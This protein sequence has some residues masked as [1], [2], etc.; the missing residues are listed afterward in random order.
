M[1]ADP[2]DWRAPIKALT[3]GDA[4]ETMLAFAARQETAIPT[5]RRCGWTVM[6]GWFR[7]PGVYRA[8]V[9]RADI[10]RTAEREHPTDPAAALARAL[11]AVTAPRDRG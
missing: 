1:S 3:G 11:L 5:R 2:D 10:A 4:V 7:S 9:Y 8:R 6:V